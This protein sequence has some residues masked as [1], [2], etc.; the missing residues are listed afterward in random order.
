MD[1]TNPTT[2]AKNR[3]CLCNS[4]SKPEP[5][6]EI[7]SETNPWSSEVYGSATPTA[8]NGELRR[9]QWLHPQPCTTT[10]LVLEEPT[11]HIRFTAGKLIDAP[12]QAMKISYIKIHFHSKN[13]SYTKCTPDKPLSAAD[14]KELL[15]RPKY[16]TS[17]PIKMPVAHTTGKGMPSPSDFC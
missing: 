5:S 16:P 6:N 11:S 4:R 8:K 10:I 13:Y 15:S 7:T 1:V 2:A 14:D 12:P 9:N 17:I 3:L